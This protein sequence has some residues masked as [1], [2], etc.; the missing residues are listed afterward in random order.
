[1]SVLSAWR[2]L[3]ALVFVAVGVAVAASADRADKEFF[4][5]RI[6]TTKGRPY[7]CGERVRPSVEITNETGKPLTYF[8]SDHET[9]A[10]TLITAI[11][12]TLT[13]DGEPVPLATGGRRVIRP[14]PLGKP[15]ERKL[16]SRDILRDCLCLEPKCPFLPPGTYT[17]QATLEQRD[18]LSGRITGKAHSNT[19]VFTV[20]EW[21]AKVYLEKMWN[22]MGAGYS[23]A[24][25]VRLVE[26]TDGDTL[27]YWREQKGD[28]ST[29]IQ[30]VQIEPRVRLDS[31][32]WTA[33][34]DY[35]HIVCDNPE[36]GKRMLILVDRD[37]SSA[38]ILDLEPAG[39]VHRAGR[40]VRIWW[41]VAAA[42]GA[43]VYLCFW[44]GRRR[45][46]PSTV[47]VQ[48]KDSTGDSSAPV[49]DT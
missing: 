31:V 32:E 5:I 34:A 10:E 25:I 36:P 43:A 11:T 15:G 18:L 9:G 49:G 20:K 22:E 40:G 48:P 21:K 23:R 1:M 45:K 42:T 33:A 2:A 46:A 29:R 13:R 37:S 44:L 6:G 17:L 7:L 38:N 30:V 4:T 35:C 14:I 39:P 8:A 28:F 3:P 12:I 16:T 26:T 27:V 41:V 47:L 24:Y 19:L